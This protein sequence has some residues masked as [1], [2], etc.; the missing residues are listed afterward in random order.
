MSNDD[1]ARP[2]GSAVHLSRRRTIQRRRKRIVPKTEERRDGGEDEEDV[3][4]DVSITDSYAS[5]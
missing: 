2:R 5:L 1:T 4:V 3:D